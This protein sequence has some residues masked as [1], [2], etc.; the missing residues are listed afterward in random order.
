MTS[1]TGTESIGLRFGFT[2]CDVDRTIGLAE[3]GFTTPES[4]LAIA[5]LAPAIAAIAN[6]L[7]LATKFVSKFTFMFL[8]VSLHIF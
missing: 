7:K 3:S 1:E 2:S 8:I 4:G 6:A 5:G